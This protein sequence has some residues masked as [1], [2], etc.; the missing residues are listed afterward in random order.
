MNKIKKDKDERVSNKVSENSSKKS[1]VKQILP[2]FKK[3]WKLLEWHF[4]Q[5]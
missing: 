3:E 2:Y 1:V 5:C 4:L